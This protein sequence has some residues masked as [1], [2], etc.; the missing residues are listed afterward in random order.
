MTPSTNHPRS[1]LPHHQ[2]VAYRVALE[3]LVAVKAAGIRDAK[4]ADQAMRAAKSACLNAAEAAGRVSRADKA[5]VLGI[6]RGEAAEAV[7]AVE[8]AE[9]SGD[10][11][12][13]SA[14]RCIP[15]AERLNA[16]LTGFIRC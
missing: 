8:I 15:I 6:A 14:D 4:L 11:A 5:R 12:I 10:A 13:G 9:L 7:A 16:L 3:L 2:L 1:R